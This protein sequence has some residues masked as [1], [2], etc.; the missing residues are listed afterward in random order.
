M[1]ISGVFNTVIYGLVRFYILG[2]MKKYW[3]LGKHEMA[4]MQQ[5]MAY[6]QQPMMAQP[7]QPL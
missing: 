7:A 4:G 1:I 3:E 6:A 5:P 2:V